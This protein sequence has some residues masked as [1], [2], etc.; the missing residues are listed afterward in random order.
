MS[1]IIC[2]NCKNEIPEQS[3]FC[4]NC[5]YHLSTKPNYSAQQNQPTKTKQ[6]GE[7]DSALSIF[8]LVFSLFGCTSIVGLI[9][10]IID[11]ATHNGKRKVGSIAA[12][13]VCG[14]WA[15]IFMIRLVN[16]HTQAETNQISQSATITQEI[17]V[18]DSTSDTGISISPE[19]IYDD[20]NVLIQVTGYTPTSN[21]GEIEIYLENN[22]EFNYNFTAHSYAVNGIMTG[23]N[24][25]DMYC[26][27]S[28]GKKAN[29]T[30]NIDSDII[31]ATGDPQ[32]ITVLFWAYDDDKSMKSFETEPIVIKTNIYDGSRTDITGETKY[33]TNGV[34]VDLLSTTP[35]CY[36]YVLTNS[37][38]SYFDFDV[39]NISINDF[40]VSDTDFDLFNEE[41]LNDC[42]LIFEVKLDKDFAELNNISSIDKLE[43]TLKIRPNG[44]YSNEWPTDIIVTE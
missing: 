37:T 30:I 6:S 3:K 19:T 25:Y 10:A 41:I 28:A 13:V 15:V 31:N 32:Y 39:D 12:L 36:T 2:P 1:T 33:D 11:L 17:Q 43:F 14:I 42:Q 38:G 29:T 23:N 24:I 4:P 7:K 8:A 16:P 34:K 22:S 5:G 44:D 27:V 20:N 18:E 26:S 21:G 9:L 35:D 40:T